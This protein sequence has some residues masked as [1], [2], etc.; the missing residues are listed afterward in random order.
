M[1]SKCKVNKYEL[2]NFQTNS[3]PQIVSIYRHRGEDRGGGIWGIK[4][5]SNRSILFIRV[6]QRP[7]RTHTFGVEDMSD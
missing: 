4:M 6:T 3:H 1:K 2:P 7:T 5:L